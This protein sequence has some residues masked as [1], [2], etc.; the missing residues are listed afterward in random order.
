MHDTRWNVHAPYL[1]TSSSAADATTYPRS[2][3][4]DASGTGRAMEASGVHVPPKHQ[5]AGLQRGV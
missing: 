5:R 1:L 4:K 2:T 3:R